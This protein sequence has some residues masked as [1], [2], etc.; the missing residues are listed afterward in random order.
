MNP[1]SCSVRRATI[2]DLEALKAIWRD[3]GF[4][5]ESLVK[6]LKDFQVVLSAEGRVLGTI[7]LRTAARQGWIYC[8]GFQDFEHADRLRPLL[9][10]R[11]G[12]LSRNQ[13]L[14]RLWTREES[15]FWAQNGFHKAEAGELE[16]LPA[17]W[18]ADTGP[19]WRVLQLREE[20][21]SENLDKK[22]AL[23]AALERKTTRSELEKAR[24]MR[25]IAGVLAV[26]L[27]ILAF[28]A[29]VYVIR[30]RPRGT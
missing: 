27:C 5:V 29:L 20:G 9:W 16:R 24:V 23:I 3:M 15:L 21:F 2:D 17:E 10:E 25:M 4:D 12:V 6:S 14:E 11:M 8:E 13:C 7:G 26:L 1:A 28:A 18:N 30:H 19:A 22:V